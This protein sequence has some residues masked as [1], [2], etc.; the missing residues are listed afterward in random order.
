[1]GDSQQQ[2]VAS[3]RAQLMVERWSIVRDQLGLR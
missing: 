2:M 3:R 1:M